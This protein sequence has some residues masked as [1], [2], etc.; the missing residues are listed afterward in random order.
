MAASFTRTGA[1]PATEVP[2][3]SH[4][5]RPTPARFDASGRI[6]GESLRS[7]G[8]IPSLDGL[9]AVS[10]A[11]VL[12]A[13]AGNTSHTS[14]PCRAWIM[15][16]LGN[17]GLGVSIFF[18]ISGFLITTLLLGEF[19]ETR[20]ISL[21]GFYLRRAFRILPAFY[22]YLATIAILGVAGKLRVTPHEFF[23]AG[24]FVWNYGFSNSTWFLG[25]TWS[26]SVEEQFYVVWPV[27]ILILKPRRA[28][29]LAAALIAAAPPIR[30]ITYYCSP[31]SRG[32]IPIMLHTRV[33]T[34]MFG[35]LAALHFYDARFVRLRRRLYR[36]HL[37]VFAAIYLFFVS[38][39]LSLKL[40]GGY[41]LPIGFTLQGAAIA[42][43]LVWAIE[44]PRNPIARPLNWRAV[45]FTGVISYS[46]YLW[47]QLF[48][49][50]EEYPF[51]QTLPL[52][53]LCA[54]AAAVGSYFLI[55]RPFLRL[56][57]RLTVPVIGS[58]KLKDPLLLPTGPGI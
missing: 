51:R 52:N 10:I 42:L 17:G 44:H 49:S 27:A 34:L 22:T 47:Q 29:I 30:L 54:I 4:D 56:R 23:S 16:V 25:H 15:P 5:E 13:H 14:F 8:R 7:S 41:D 57:Y 45:A 31:A 28:S 20:T 32:H 46:L 1:A 50:P 18:G 11:L 33:D 6:N 12:A 39:F 19:R 3:L 26:L 43:I 36:V 35:C 2:S 24:L 38:P 48:L 40:R 9:R 58:P 21:K 37:H 55:E 53:L